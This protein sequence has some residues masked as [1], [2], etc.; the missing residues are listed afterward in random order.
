MLRL[1]FEDGVV[2]EWAR[3]SAK[4]KEEYKEII[5]KYELD[6]VI[7][8]RISIDS[9]VTNDSL[10]CLSS[11]LKRSLSCYTHFNTLD[12]HAILITLEISL[13]AHIKL[14][15]FSNDDRF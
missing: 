14:I 5:Q 13:L 15:E 9:H 11:S 1:C 10:L 4:N 2:I 6:M 12:Y 7:A 3:K 8:E